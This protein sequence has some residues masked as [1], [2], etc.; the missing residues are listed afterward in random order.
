MCPAPTADF[1]VVKTIHLGD[2]N[3]KK[4]APPDGD[5]YPGGQVS[6][7]SWGASCEGS[8]KRMK[9][10]LKAAPSSIVVI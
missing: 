7:L 10:L 1:V 5:G 3:A 4:K 8:E 6:L 2:H 9:K